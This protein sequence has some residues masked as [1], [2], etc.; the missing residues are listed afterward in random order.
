MLSDFYL[1]SPLPP[2][3]F[4]KECADVDMALLSDDF[5]HSSSSSSSLLL[6]PLFDVPPPS[7]SFR[8][9]ETEH[10]SR[11]ASSDNNSNQPTLSNDPCMELAMALAGIDD[12]EGITMSPS[13]GH[14][15]LFENYNNNNSQPL[16][17]SGTALDAPLSSSLSSS[18]P[19]E[20]TYHHQQ[21]NVQPAAAAAWMHPDCP[22]CLATS[23]SRGGAPLA[24]TEEATFAYS[25][26]AALRSPVRSHPSLLGGGHHREPPTWGCGSSSTRD[27]LMGFQFT[28]RKRRFLCPVNR[29]GHV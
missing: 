23:P 20:T 7:R 6:Q 15:D 10:H 24:G 16:F 9:G 26:A 18:P 19:Y 12:E 22:G 2:L 17:F 27:P 5:V 13:R 21:P 3:P 25:T 11:H 8:G 29:G 14:A 28:R 4:H 1:P